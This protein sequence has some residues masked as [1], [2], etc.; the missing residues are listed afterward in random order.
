MPETDKSMNK[1]IPQQ[2]QRYPR[3]PEDLPDWEE[4]RGSFHAGFARSKTELDEILRLRY[5]VFNVECGEAHSASQT[6]GIEEDEYDANCHHI[7]VRDLRS[8]DVVGTYRM[9]TR[10][11]ASLGSGFY[12]N[13]EFHLDQLPEHTLNQGVEVGRACIAEKNRKGVVL[14]LLFRG[15]AAYMVERQKSFLFG[16]GS[17]PSVDRA[18]A[19][20]ALQTF[21]ER[22][23][24]HPEFHIETM[25]SYDQAP[26]LQNPEDHQPEQAIPELFEIYFSLGARVTSAPAFDLDFGTTDFLLHFDF[27]SMEPT[28]LR[29]YVD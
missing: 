11:L 27:A 9:L 18:T 24:L 20:Q 28:L 23:L 26:L 4:K 15:I 19:Q 22:E 8:G 10:E 12:S 21:K 6:L 14:H 5:E 17:L 13:R 25:P 1:S 29:K 16:C 2:P 3:R 7:V